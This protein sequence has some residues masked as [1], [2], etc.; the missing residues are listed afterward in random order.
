M[1]LPNSNGSGS[2]TVSRD[3]VRKNFA[4]KGPRITRM[5]N[6]VEGRHGGL[7]PCFGDFVAA[8]DRIT[9]KK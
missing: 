9:P 6:L 2:E 8:L 5:K 1:Q 7:F 3:F 4:G